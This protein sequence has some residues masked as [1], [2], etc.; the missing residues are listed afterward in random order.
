M[1]YCD[2][3]RDL[4]EQQ[5]VGVVENPNMTSTVHAERSPSP[6]PRTPLRLVLAQRLCRVLPPVVSMRLG[7]MLYPQAQGFADDFNFIVKA[8]TGSHFAGRTSDF[9]GHPFSIHGYYEWRNWALAAAVCAPGD[10]IVE[11]GANVGTETVGFR[12]IV[13]STG[14]VVAFEP[15]PGNLASLRA[16]VLLN[17]WT[18]VEIQPCALGETETRL[19]FALPPH[20]HASGVGHFVASKDVGTAQTIEV[21]CRT[22][23][24][25]IDQLGQATAIF[26][27]A[28]GAETMILRGGRHYLSRFTPVV[29]L[30]AS[31]KHLA[32]AGSSL[33][34]L[35][36]TLQSMGYQA[37]AVG[38]LGLEPVTDLRQ[39]STSNWLCVHESMSRL[40][41]R[42]SSAI[43]RCGLMPCVRGLN[44]LCR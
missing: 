5:S 10:C 35:H 34:E 33:A 36:G 4:G 12:D 22:L 25:L 39:P 17:R 1:R 40:V 24:S 8:Q 2:S 20:K 21:Q 37:F 38:R 28:E 16:L 11:I 3:S 43:A 42:C 29:V 32:R 18:N 30:E 19:A 9:Q 41:D 6:G 23:D 14:R 13:G 31:P 15:V 27:D 7:S 44:P 26:C